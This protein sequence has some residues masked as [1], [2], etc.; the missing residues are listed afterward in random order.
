MK[1]RKNKEAVDF[2]RQFLKERDNC[3]NCM[4]TRQVMREEGF[5]NGQIHYAVK[6]LSLQPLR[7]SIPGAYARSFDGWML[8]TS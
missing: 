5:T 3:F 7:C 8:P 2:L 4:W 1:R 6:A